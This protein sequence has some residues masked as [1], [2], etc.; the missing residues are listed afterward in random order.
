MIG[1]AIVGV[2]DKVGPRVVVR[3][4]PNAVILRDPSGAE[5]TVLLR[6]AGVDGVKSVPF[7]QARPIAGTAP[8]ERGTEQ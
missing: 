5:I 3:I 8:L 6:T 7:P 4:E 2:G 1:G